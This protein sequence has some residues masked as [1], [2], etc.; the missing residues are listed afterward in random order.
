MIVALGIIG[1]LLLVYIGS[2]LLQLKVK[3]LAFVYSIFVCL[4]AVL[5][6]IGNWIPVAVY[7]AGE[8]FVIWIIIRFMGF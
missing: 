3:S 6:I 2:K 5:L 7:I 1:V 4:Y 8:I